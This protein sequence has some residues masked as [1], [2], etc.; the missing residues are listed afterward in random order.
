MIRKIIN[1]LID[2]ID[3]FIKSLA[4]FPRKFWFVVGVSFIDRVGGTML[5]PFFTLYITQKF[6][7][8]MTEAGT[9]LGTFS[10]FGMFGSMIGGALT[11]R[12]GRRRL[13]LFGLVFSAVST[14]ALGS[15]NEFAILYPLAVFIGLLSDVAGPAHSA[16]IAD[17]LPEDKRQE[18]FG[19]LRVVANV[20][21]M[22][23]PIIGGFL[24]NRSYFALFVTDAV[25]SCIVA[26]LFYLF[27]PE[28]KPQ[29]AALPHEEVQ[30]ETMLQT[31]LGYIK[32]LRDGPYVAFLGASIL[33]GL[34]YQQMY[35]SLSYYLNKFHGIEPSGYGFL[36]TS[37][38]ITVVLFQFL[39]TYLIK[40]RPPFLTMAVGVLFYVLGFT[41]FGVVSAYWLFVTAI[42]V[43][44]IGEMIIMPVSSALTANFAPADMRG[45]YMAIY[46]LSWG[47]PAIVGPAAAGLIIDGPNPNLLWFL[48]GALTLVS[49]ASFYFLH[50]TLGKQ[51]RF[52][53]QDELAQPLPSATD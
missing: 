18:G 14:L 45:R 38:A 37:S 26:L 32:V 4:G 40:K 5:F 3:N 10:L 22:I 30:H 47:L 46:G 44:T 9:V 29:V 43:I 1:W 15:V 13:I 33:M 12:L 34:V 20:S 36:M 23:G 8:G 24:A 25:I 49:A 6:H 52:I 51:E 21:W 35:N 16:M 39:V 31:F 17:I 11:D 2:F 48:G 42:V 27:M 53:P 28:T 50:L 19:I 41:M 7:V